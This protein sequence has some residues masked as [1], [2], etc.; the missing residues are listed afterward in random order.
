MWALNLDRDPALHKIN[1]RKGQELSAI[2]ICRH[3]LVQVFAGHKNLGFTEKYRQSGLEE[4]TT[5]I[6][7]H[8]SVRVKEMR[9]N[10]IF[11]VWTYNQKS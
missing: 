4:L 2:V 10:I 11:T 6:R 3:A 9:Q 5:A 1:V 8:P 7:K